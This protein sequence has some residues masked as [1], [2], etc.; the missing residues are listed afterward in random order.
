[1]CPVAG[2]DHPHYRARADDDLIARV[3]QRF[4]EAVLTAYDR[5]LERVAVEGAATYGSGR[6]DRHATGL[7]LTE[8]GT[9][10]ARSRTLSAPRRGDPRH[11]A[12]APLFAEGPRFGAPPL[13]NGALKVYVVNINDLTSPPWVASSKRSSAGLAASSAADIRAA[14]SAV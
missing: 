7:L 1:M 9:P 5:G 13:F 4:R 12:S 11:L 2:P 14:P 10:A 8:S 6:S 3:A